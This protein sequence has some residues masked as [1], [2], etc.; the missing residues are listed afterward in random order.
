[1]FNREIDTKL[2]R[3]PVKPQGKQPQGSPPQQQGSQGGHQGQIRPK[4]PSQ[5]GDLVYKRNE[6]KTTTKGPWEPEPHKI[7]KVVHNQVT[8]TRRETESLRDRKDWKLVKQRP[9][10]DNHNE[11]DHNVIT[12]DMFKEGDFDDYEPNNRQGP[13]RPVTRSARTRESGDAPPA[14]TRNTRY[15]DGPPTE[16]DKERSGMGEHAPQTTAEGDPTPVVREA[17]NP[18]GPAEPDDSTQREGDVPPSR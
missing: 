7:T 17:Q 4:A 6:T 12:E 1:M 18:M 14:P 8:A 13:D 5:V 11:R 3:I 15:G 16:G 9:I 2:P 10:P